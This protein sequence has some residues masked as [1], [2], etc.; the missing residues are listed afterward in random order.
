MRVYPNS[1]PA[2]GGINISLLLVPRSI[3]PSRLRL[4]NPRSAAR[5]VVCLGFGNGAVGFRA[6]R[7]RARVRHKAGRKRG[8]KVG[9][10][11]F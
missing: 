5:D 3:R 7:A 1:Y 9:R 11:D 8:V 10:R 2:Y 4:R 6:T